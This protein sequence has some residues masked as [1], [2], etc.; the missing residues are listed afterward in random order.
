M[1]STL[2]PTFASMLPLQPT[3]SD[4]ASCYVQRY[5]DLQ[6]AVKTRKANTSI[7]EFLRRHWIAHGKLEGRNPFCHSSTAADPR[8]PDV[9]RAGRGHA[10]GNEQPPGS[11]TNVSAMDH[12]RDCS[13]RR[14]RDMKD[15]FERFGYVYYSSCSLRRRKQLLPSLAG[16]T[17]DKLGSL[18]TGYRAQDG[19]K[20]VESV[21]DAAADHDINAFLAYLHDGRRATPFQ[22]LNFARGT[23]QATHSD[24]V[25]FDT[26][27]TR[28]L[29]AAV[30]LALEDIHPTA[31]PLVFYPGSHRAGLWDFPQLGMPNA[32]PAEKKTSY[33]RYVAKLKGVIETLGLRPS[34]ASDVA[35]GDAFVWAASLLHGGSTVLDPNRTRLSQ[36]TH[37]WIDGAERY[38][39]PRVSGPNGPPHLKDERDWSQLAR[40]A[41]HHA[42]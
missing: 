30:W 38:W 13:D 24:V 29:M 6:A 40:L 19:W 31:G 42:H 2:Q 7:H 33:F 41:A 4:L 36:V 14:Y 26:L 39:V 25:H 22:T 15:Q 12:W 17:R 21:A 28:G 11:R 23:Q 35:R 32:M 20:Q 8:E 27:P 16:F 3:N 5:D 10:H 18:G 37:Y 1:L 9:G 34:Y